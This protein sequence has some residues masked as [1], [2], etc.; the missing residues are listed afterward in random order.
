[1]SYNTTEKIHLNAFYK[2]INGGN[3]KGIDTEKLNELQE[4]AKVY[5]NSFY[6]NQRNSE[7]IETMNRIKCRS[8]VNISNPKAENTILFIFSVDPTFEAIKIYG[9][10]NHIKQIKE[11]MIKY[12]G[13]YDKNLIIIEKA[14]IKRFLS[15][16]EINGLEEEI[17]KRVYK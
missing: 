15:K 16:I 10:C 3:F 8:I 2:S 1:M 13:I 12:F 17:E 5:R 14:F 7:Y 4:L 9:E 11:K 6:N